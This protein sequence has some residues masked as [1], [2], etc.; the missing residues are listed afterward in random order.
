[1]SGSTKIDNAVCSL[2]KFL[3]TRFIGWLKYFTKNLVVIT[4][5]FRLRSMLSLRVKTWGVS[6]A[7]RWNGIET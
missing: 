3:T 5:I 1:M 6:T 2:P 4:A 7:R